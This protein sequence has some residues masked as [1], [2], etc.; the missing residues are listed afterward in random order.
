MRNKKRLTTESK[1]S[2]FLGQLLNPVGCA[3]KLQNSLP[4][5][6]VFGVAERHYL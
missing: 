5:L 1:L 3:L 6:A 4:D 2:S